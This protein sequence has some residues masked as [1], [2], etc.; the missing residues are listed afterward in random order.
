[1]ETPAGWLAEEG[2]T[3]Q[4]MDFIHHGRQPG[5]AGQQSKHES[6]ENDESDHADEVAEYRSN[7][8]IE[9]IISDIKN[10]HFHP[11]RMGTIRL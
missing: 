9:R 10:I 7:P 4:L 3:M 11:S 6:P 2:K 1:M 5:W 8:V